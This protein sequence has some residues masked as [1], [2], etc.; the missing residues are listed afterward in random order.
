M[1]NV[2]DIETINID[3]TQYAVAD[4]SE[5]VQKLVEIFNEWNQ[6]EANI[7]SKLMMLQAAKDSLSRQIIDQ[8]KSDNEP[9]KEETDA[10]ETDAEESKE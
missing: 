4:A 3:E 9:V 7:R 6:E 10:E 5:K 1:P 2:T 8:I